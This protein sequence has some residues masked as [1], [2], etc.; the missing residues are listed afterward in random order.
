MNSIVSWRRVPR[1]VFG[2]AVFFL[3]QTSGLCAVPSQPTAVVGWGFN[4][5]G[6]ASPPGGLTNVTAISAGSGQGVALRAN[7]TVTSWGFAFQPGLPA[8][9]GDIAAIECG[10]GHTLALRSNGTVVAWGENESGQA[11]I[12]PGLSNVVAV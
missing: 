3:V 4:N 6:Q 8:G 12:P 11:S 10:R 7:G 5:H 2:Q 9:L 1:L